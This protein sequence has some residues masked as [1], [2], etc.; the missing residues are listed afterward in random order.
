[1][2]QWR[3]M[4]TKEVKKEYDKRYY[5][6]HK[7]QERERSRKYR[8]IHKKQQKEY[9]RKYSQSHKKQIRE[10][11]RKYCQSHRKQVNKNVREYRHS[12]PEKVKKWEH[13]KYMRS[14]RQN[15]K[16]RLDKI[17]GCVVRKALKGKKAGR[18]WEVL[19]GYT[20]EDL[21]RHLESLFDNKMTWENYGLYW[22]IDHFKPKSLFYYEIA[23]DPEFKECWALENLQPMEKSENRKKSNHYQM[24]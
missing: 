14:W 6:T 4:I 11:H 8:Q 21:I 16:Y 5:Q 12:H 3:Y 19:T 1:M 10:R 24:E 9:D 7:R 20:I 18:R 22:E 17:M 23:E 2:V 13:T 15:P